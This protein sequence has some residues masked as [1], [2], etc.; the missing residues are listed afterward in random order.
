[1]S[2]PIELV[3]ICKSFA[4]TP[5]LRGVDL[6]LR[7]GSIHAL[8]GENGAGKSTLMAILAGLLQ[9]DSG[10][11][12]Q[13]G[14]PV[15]F[16]DARAAWR[17]GIVMVHQ[18]VDLFTDL[19]VLENLGWQQGFPRWAG[20]IDWT[21]QRKRTAQALAAV[22]SPVALDATAG[23]LTPGQ[24]Q[25]VEIAGAVSRQA[26]VLILDEPTSSLSARESHRLFEFLR[27]FRA[28]GTAIVYVSHR[29]EEI[30][31][32]ADEITV[33]RD[34]QRV[35]TGPADQTTP[36][37]LIRHMVGRDV[38]VTRRIT[39]SGTGRVRLACSGLTAA[40]GSFRNVSLEVRGG[41]I[42][43]VYGLIGAGRSEWAQ[44]IFGLEPIAQGT[45]AIDGQP[46]HPSDP[47][48][49]ANL[50][51][52]YVPED[53]LRQGLCRQLSVGYNAVMTLL[54]RLAIHGWLPPNRERLAAQ[55]I[56]EPLRVR[57]ANLE[58]PI[59]TLSGGNQQK[60]ILGRWLAREP[61][62][63]LLDEPTRGV[64]VGARA[65]IYTLIH[66]LSQR[67][68]AIV[69]I[70]S[71]LPEVLSQSDKLAVFREGELVAQLP[72]HEA[73]AEQVA[74][75]ALPT[76]LAQGM[77]GFGSRAPT[78]TTASGC[79][80]GGHLWAFLR[81]EGV[82]ACFLIVFFLAM[83]L[84][85]GR[86]LQLENVR[87]LVT[88]SALLGLCA[89][90]AALVLMAGGLDIS[91][92]ALL[93]LSAGVAGQLW[94]RGASLPVV[95]LVAVTVGA[96]GGLANAAL[97]LLGRVHPIVVTLGTMSIYRG[98]TLWWLGQD[99]QIPPPRRDWLLESWLGL[100]L[101]SWVVLGIAV[102][103]WFFLTYTVAGRQL[104]ALGSNPRA[105]HRVGIHKSRVWL[106][107][108]TVQGMLIGLAG[109]LYLARSGALQPTS[110]ESRTLEAI[111]AAVVGGVAITGGRGSVLGLLLGALLLVAIGS[112]CV[113]LQVSTRWQQAVVG[114]VLLLAVLA[115][116]L[117][118]EKRP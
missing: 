57:L 18:E 37:E 102:G 4:G 83:H 48:T 96:A 77:E 35:W 24:R 78:G 30:F 5:A 60:V 86:F 81:G 14:Q 115:D 74:E 89:L 3:G 21:T 51:I 113:F 90:G 104:I 73:N 29:F 50:G 100:P 55:K 118:R 87:N 67:G 68:V 88:D 47:G 64:D 107:A 8:V 98:L 95:V 75:L 85:T 1:M 97:S 71:D 26:R 10:T 39:S 22:G 52:A 61:R 54:E 23:T 27:R 17:A 38:E 42:L 6:A 59:G 46:I 82:L 33:L 9:P 20:C 36:Q 65:E 112:A 69:L 25:L 76:S 110:H 44:A 114:A 103:A 34:G 79:W 66:D 11:L 40:N 62:V 53:R 15:H 108:F 93:A 99:V 43:G 84:S 56:I 109:V 105:A 45:L 111:A 72:A 94:E 7:P 31:A 101:V 2:Q 12:L 80:I 117:G 58:Q 92:G 19:S 63:L 41:E 32:L 106:L 16:A 49:M 28:E 70:S 13:D 116:A 91:L